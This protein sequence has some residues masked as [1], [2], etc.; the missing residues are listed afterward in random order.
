MIRSLLSSGRVHLEAR[1]GGKPSE[2]P[3]ACGWRYDSAGSWFPLGECIGWVGDDDVLLEPTGA[4]RAVQVAGRDI[5]EV[6]AVSEQTLRKRLHE[7]NLLV[8]V[9]EARQTLTVRRSIAGIS[10]NV[11]HFHRNTILPELSDAD[12][13]AA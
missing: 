6:L 10:K 7:K 1:C 11:L 3:E 2:S 8:S 13:D 4:F 5:G 12:E 9:D